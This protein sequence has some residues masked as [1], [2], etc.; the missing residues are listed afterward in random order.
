MKKKKIIF[1]LAHVHVLVLCALMFC[2]VCRKGQ[3]SNLKIKIHAS[4]QSTYYSCKKNNNKKNNVHISNGPNKL[5]I[6]SVE[7]KKNISL[8]RWIK[9]MGKRSSRS[10]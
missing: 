4:K 6:N 9:R 7:M 3:K 1:S 2:Q 10:C 8:M 5:K